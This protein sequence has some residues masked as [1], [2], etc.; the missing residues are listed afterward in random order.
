MEKPCRYRLRIEID[1]YNNY[2]ASRWA[3]IGFVSETLLS[4][5]VWLLIIDPL[6][7]I[8]SVKAMFQPSIFQPIFTWWFRLVTHYLLLQLCSNYYNG[9]PLTL[10]R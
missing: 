2:V 6:S 9:T 8:F 4:S 3:M 10:T 7:I 1:E 5:L